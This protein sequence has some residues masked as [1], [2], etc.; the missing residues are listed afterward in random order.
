MAFL[1]VRI[2]T[3]RPGAPVRFDVH[4]LVA[5]KYVHYIRS[6]DTFDPDRI[7]RLRSKG[8]KKLYIPEESEPA[9]LAYLDAGLEDLSNK[10][11]PLEERSSLVGSAIVTDAE[12]ALHNCETEQGY[13]RTE[14]RIGKVVSFLTSE[15]GA[16]KNILASTGCSL[17]NFQHAA[18]VTSLALGLANRL[19]ITSARDLL[20]L[21]IAGLLHD[22][23]L[24]NLGFGADVQ[25]ENLS[26]A[27][28]KQYQKHPTEVAHLLAGKPYIN[29]NILELIAN[30]E[31]IGEGAGFP[32]KK[33]LSTLPLSS[34]VLNLCD[35]YDHFAS[36]QRMAPLDA[37]KKFFSDK[38]GFFNLDHI[39]E[40]SA[41]LK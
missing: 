15:D 14:D 2:G 39:R 12:N 32:Q 19:G 27:E 28:L 34:Q 4:I 3:L 16:I 18:N 6:A 9:Y 11:L 10:D 37:A 22:S 24:M 8:V 31:E 41:L 23:A 38:I 21:G 35:A 26:V 33:R 36:V 17:D 30:H 25:P 40:L 29:R 5:E 13:H 1:P 20:D 7:E